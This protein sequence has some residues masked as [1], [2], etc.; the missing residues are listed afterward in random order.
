MKP[1]A[2]TAA[3]ARVVFGGGALQHLGREI[4]ALGAQR[5][6]VLST[7]EQKDSALR[8]AGLLGGRAAGVYAE[9]RMHVPI[10]TARASPSSPSRPPTP[11]AR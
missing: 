10:E 11:A 7:P 8:V 5:A 3:T 4:A 6:L 9:A 1:F 2:Y